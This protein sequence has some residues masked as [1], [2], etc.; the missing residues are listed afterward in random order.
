MICHSDRFT[1]NTKAY[2]DTAVK[3][4]FSYLQGTKYK[5]VVFNPYNK[6]VVDFCVDVYSAG[7]WGHKNPQDPICA[8]IRNLIVVKNKIVIYCECQR[9]IHRLLSII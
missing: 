1:H 3:S 9:Y 6:M 4:I 2:H 8:N 5:G 7:L